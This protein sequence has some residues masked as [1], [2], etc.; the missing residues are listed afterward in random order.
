MWPAIKCMY[1][2]YIYNLAHGLQEPNWIYGRSCKMYLSEIINMVL[3]LFTVT[4]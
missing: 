4:F 3:L 2:E 1:K